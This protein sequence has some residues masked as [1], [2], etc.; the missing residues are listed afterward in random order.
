MGNKVFQFPKSMPRLLLCV[1][2]LVVFTET[3]NDKCL[4]VFFRNII[5]KYQRFNASGVSEDP[6]T[7]Y[8][9]KFVGEHVPYTEQTF[10]RNGNPNLV[11]AGIT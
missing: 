4:I 8:R 5:E 11:E 2:S 3:I 6:L 9:F 10:G 1:L 7:L